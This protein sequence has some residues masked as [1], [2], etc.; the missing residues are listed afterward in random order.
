V[1][2]SDMTMHNV[3]AL[4]T[5]NREFNRSTQLKGTNITETFTMAEVPIRFMCNVHSWMAAWVGAVEHP[6]FAVTDASGA[7]SIA[8]VPPGTYTVEAWHETLGAKTQ[9][10]TIGE[11]Q[12]GSLSFTFGQAQ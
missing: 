12:H 9:T 3:H 2:N 8:G 5:K 11:K 6:F 10:I 1:L 4:P 7:F